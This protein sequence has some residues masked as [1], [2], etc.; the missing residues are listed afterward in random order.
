MT[1]AEFR[2][3]LE[4]NIAK[5]IEK[6]PRL[7]DKRLFKGLDRIIVNSSSDFLTL[8]TIPHLQKLLLTQF[9]LQKRIEAS[10]QHEGVMQQPLFLKAF[11]TSFRIGTA[12]VFLDSYRFRREQLL[13]G[14]QIL[15][16]GIQEIPH[17]FYLWHHPELPY[18]FCYFEVHKLR[19]EE[20]SKTGVKKLEL[21]LREQLHATPSPTPALFWP[22]NEEESFRQVQLLLKEMRHPEDLPHVSIHFREQTP[23]SL[24]FLIHMARPRNSELLAHSLGRLPDYLEYFCHFQ[25]NIQYPF[26]IELGAFALKVASH[27]FDVPESINLLYARRYVLKYLEATFGT[28]RDYNGGLFEKQQQHFE[29]IR[30]LLSDKI[31]LFDLFAEKV[32]YALLPV[33]K[34]L[35]LTFKEAE[36]L[37]RAFSDLMQGKGSF[38]G[39]YDS[40][41][42]TIIKAIH[43]SDLPRF[44]HISKESKKK[45][46]HARLSFGGFYYHCVL[47]SQMSDIN[48]FL[49][50]STSP[51]EKT[52]I[53]RLIFEEGQPTSLNPYHT[54]GDMRCRLLCKLLF[55]GLFRL[56]AQGNPE[57]AG[58]LNL[59]LS[60][61]GTVY[62]FKLRPNRWSNGERVTAIDYV[63]SL[64][65]A[66]RGL[67]SHP[68]IYFAIKNAQ[69]FKEKKVDSNDLGI[70]ALSS[71]TLQIELEHPDA[72]F[73][74]H[75]A[76]PFFFPIFG[77]MQE[78]IWFNG[79]YLVREKNKEA[80]LLE[81]NPYFWN[82]KRIY[83]EEINIRWGEDCNTYFSLFQEGKI[84]WIGDPLSTLAPSLIQQLE[85]DGKLHRQEACRRFLVCFNTKHPTLASHWIRRALSIAIDRSLIC[86]TI[87][88]HSSPFFPL[89]PAK[90]ESNDYFERGLREL[91]LTRETFP[92][93]TFSFSHQARRLKLAECLQS[94][95]QEILGINVDLKE[96]EW[97]LFRNRLEKGHFEITGTI[98]DIEDEDSP[99]FL[100][101]FE[102]LN[103]WNFSKWQNLEYRKIIAKAKAE[104]ED[105]RRQAYLS[106]AKQI[107]IDEAPFTPLFK[108]THLYAHTPSLKGY[109]FDEE[110]CVD[111]SQSHF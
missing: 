12:F 76:K 94:V 11:C 23:S 77:S 75:L 62:H 84:N 45:I 37:F 13:K 79:P 32:F 107:L 96:I 53:L 88:I 39:K 8:R 60:H 51:R 82:A 40:E 27:A 41:S 110:G 50:Q 38:T 111:F 43:P 30:S 6:Y 73:L 69:A 29:T 9:F 16:P 1:D 36:D 71:D 104:V 103:T 17:S 2:F 48:T 61:N 18:I 78:P 44:T 91:G 34:R 56:N 86:S 70:R 7:F 81:K 74:H 55:E 46:A 10:L 72:H 100:E 5:A 89:L 87:F 68:E 21:S 3:L 58:S 65:M 80:I 85:Q 59:N 57:P 15:L 63:S 102:G 101:R 33:E 106:E 28:C 49:Q 19:G 67:L 108:Y 90:E 64:T 83:F 22:Y 99:R 52:K 14:L 54:G 105:I 31:P 95:W 98:Q 97:N 26:P 25:H 20:L 93:L 66:L 92:P 24:E 109:L 4:K 35:M 42:V 47:G